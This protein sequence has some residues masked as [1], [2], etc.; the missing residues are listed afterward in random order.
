MT[1]KITRPFF[2]VIHTDRQTDRAVIMFCEIRKTFPRVYNITVVTQM[3][4]S[5]FWIAFIGD[6]FGRTIYSAGF[7]LI[8]K[9]SYICINRMIDGKIYRC[10]HTA[11]SEH[12][13]EFGMN[14]GTMP[15]QF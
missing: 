9:I 11:H 14:D 12:R 4:L 15:A 5:G 13:S 8:T 1:L 7:T 6:G 3:I 2:M 10:D